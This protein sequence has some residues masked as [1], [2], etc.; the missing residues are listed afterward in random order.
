[1]KSM[2]KKRILLIT[3]ILALLLSLISVTAYA[4]DEI[5]ITIDLSDYAYSVEVAEKHGSGEQRQ[6]QFR[7]QIIRFNLPTAQQKM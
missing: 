6:E 5:V 3:I 4:A 2:M 1:M 7:H